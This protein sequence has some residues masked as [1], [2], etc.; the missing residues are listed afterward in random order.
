MTYLTI[1]YL[2]RMNDWFICY[3]SQSLHMRVQIY[4]P[5]L[6]KSQTSKQSYVDYHL[7]HSFT[8]FKE[9]LILEKQPGPAFFLLFASIWM[10]NPLQ[11]GVAFR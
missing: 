6:L 8:Y 1:V 11:P 5:Y 4:Q 9:V 7:I 10:L 2:L 3:L